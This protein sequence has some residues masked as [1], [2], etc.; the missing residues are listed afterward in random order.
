MLLFALVLAV[1]LASTSVARAQEPT[2]DQEVAGDNALDRAREALAR[3]DH[4]EARRIA[5]AYVAVRGDDADGWT[6]LG[7]ID[8]EAG[9]LEL[10]LAQ[11]GR[12]LRLMRSDDPA[13][14]IVAFNRASCHFEM[15]RFD[16]AEDGFG[17]VGKGEPPL[18]VLA[19]VNAG[20]AALEQGAKERA[21]AYLRRAQ[22][23][24]G[25]GS[26]ADAREEL[27]AA[28][29]P[30]TEELPQADGL[31]QQDDEAVAVA[32]YDAAVDAY[33]AGQERE[34]IQHFR[35]ARGRGLDA[36]R[37]AN[38][39]AY[40]DALAGG[41]RSVGR[42]W[43]S[44]VA[45]GGG[46]DSNA[47]QSGLGDASA[48]LSFVQAEQ[49]SP[50]L[51][52]SGEVGY[53]ASLSDRTFLLAEYS[54]DQLAYLEGELDLFN[55]QDHTLELGVEHGASAL[56][57]YGLSGRALL[58]LAG[59]SD[60]DPLTW[61]LGTDAWL[62]FDYGQR[63]ETTV[64]GTLLWTREA[65]EAF[66]FLAGTRSE[67]S[68]DQSVHSGRLRAGLGA[69][70]RAEGLGTQHVIT[71]PE[72]L[73]VAC[74]SIYDIPLSYRGPALS[75]WS[76]YQ[77]APSVR[78]GLRGRA[79]WRLHSAASRL[80]VITL[81]GRTGILHERT[82]RDRRTGV[83]TGLSFALGGPF[84]LYVGYDLT[85]GSSNIDNPAGDGHE[86]DY[87]NLNYVRHVGELELGAVF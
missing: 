48:P 5:T 57:R 23:L 38:A 84:E 32:D 2:G 25:D 3:G 63:W 52:A 59:L 27:A 54:L 34:S 17:H 47:A 86:L 66:T 12:A 37:D 44:S 62:T 40:L 56:V 73:C 36:I 28:L 46:F 58:S 79:E 35:R 18:A 24:D 83:S 71:E 39:V 80:D 55:S 4:A 26:L 82:Q 31:E 10:A 15:G 85:I 67:I 49:G 87:G 43:G 51:T 11:F 77:L 61:T 81:D 53:G 13:R 68:I 64:R 60:L 33:R 21:R 16:E 65:D 70:Y 6:V 1:M 72:E 30:P 7:L 29:R 14:A 78:A 74:Q 42:G 8:Y 75:L 22:A 9:E 45:V 41:L 20:F 50:Y 69:R 76:S 19:L